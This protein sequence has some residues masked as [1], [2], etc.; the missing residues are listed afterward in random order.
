MEKIYNVKLHKRDSWAM[1]GFQI[2]DA[3]GQDITACCR[4]SYLGYEISI[5]TLGYADGSCLNEINVY[6]QAGD[7]LSQY[8][9]VSDAI[10]FCNINH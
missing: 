6:N 2:V 5:T 1:Q 4:I 7:L 3:C 9:S 10:N 8:H